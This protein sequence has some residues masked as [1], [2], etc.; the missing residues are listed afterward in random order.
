MT[1][2]FDGGRG[3]AADERCFESR[4]LG[5]CGADVALVHIGRP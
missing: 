4:G 5:A 3:R 2:F 1:I